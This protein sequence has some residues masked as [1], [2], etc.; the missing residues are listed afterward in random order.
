MAALT[1]ARGDPRPRAYYERRDQHGKPATVTLVAC[2]RT[3]LSIANAV[4][5][6]GAPWR[7]QGGAVA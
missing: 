7:P 3:L 4:L 2:M 5:R 6:D 1:A